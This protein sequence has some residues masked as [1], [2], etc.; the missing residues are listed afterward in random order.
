MTAE[1]RGFGSW[2][3]RGLRAGI[4]FVGAYLLIAYLILPRFWEELDKKDD[5]DHASPTESAPGFAY[6]DEG[7][8]AGP[9][10]VE[11]VGDREQLIRA[12]VAAGW[13]PAEP[14]TFES[15]VAIVKSVV[16][17]RPDPTAPVSNLYLFDRKQALAFERE[18]GSSAD[19]RHHNRW[20]LNDMADSVGRPIWYGAAS[21]DA[22]AGLSRRTG[23]VTHLISPDL[24][25]E[26]DFLME[27]LQRAGRLERQYEVMGVGPIQDGHNAEGS[28]YHTDGMRSVGVLVADSAREDAAAPPE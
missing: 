14:I 27:S 6:N 22:R 9:I 19:R 10:N 5:V 8:R 1:R 26:R 20:W 25:S 18:V 24:D 7:G 15:S 13:R 4:V 12:L 2:A 23:Q 21:M 28:R 11:L 3:R 16:F 17:D